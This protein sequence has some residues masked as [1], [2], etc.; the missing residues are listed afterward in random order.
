MNWVKWRLLIIFLAVIGVIL[1]LTYS[2]LSGVIFTGIAVLLLPLS[3]VGD[4]KDEP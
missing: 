3:Y 2:K 1:S 4:R